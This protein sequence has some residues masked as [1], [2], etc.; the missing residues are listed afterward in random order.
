MKKPLVVRLDRVGVR[1]PRT[2][3]R[4]ATVLR[5]AGLAVFTFTPAEVAELAG[6]FGWSGL[7]RE[8][9]LD[10]EHAFQWAYLDGSIVVAVWCGSRGGPPS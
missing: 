5:L 4:D 6:G 7:L 10:P 2:Y 9:G 3:A 8:V 1:H